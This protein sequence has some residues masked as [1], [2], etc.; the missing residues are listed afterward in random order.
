MASAAR[1]SVTRTQDTEEEVVVG[2]QPLGEGGPMGG[3]AQGGVGATRPCL[4][5]SYR[6][7][8]LP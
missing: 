8:I 7:F 4:V 2:E 3:Q 5:R 1:I 6:K